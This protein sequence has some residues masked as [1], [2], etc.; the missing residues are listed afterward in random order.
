Q[1]DCALNNGGCSDGCIQGPF[2]AECTCQ[3]GYQLLNDSKTCDDIDECSIPGWCS[4]QCYNERGSFR[5]SCSD[6]YLLEPDNR[7]CKATDPTAAT[8][9][10]ASRSQIISSKVNLQ[11]P[12]IRPVVSGSDIVTVDFDRL[13]S[14]I[15]WADVSLKKIFTSF[16]NGTDRREVFSTGL[17]V[18]ES[19]AVDWVARNLYWTDSVMENIEVST[20]DGRFRKVLLTKNVTSPRGL[21]LD[22]RNH[23]NIM[24]WSD[25]GQNPRIEKAYMDGTGRQAI[26][27]TKLYW[28]NGLA[29]DYTTRRV[30]FADAYLKYIDYCDYNGNGRFQV[31]ASDM[32][33]QHPHGMTIFE[34]HIYWSERYTYQVLR[35]NKFHGGNTTTMIT[36][37]CLLSGFRPRYYTCHCQSG[38]NLNSDGRTCIKD[39]TPF[40]MVVRETVIFGIPVDPADPSN[41]AMVPVSG[42]TQGRDIDFDDQEQFV[43]W[44]QGSS[45]IYRVKTDGTNRTLFAPSAIIGSPSGLAFDWITRMMYYTNPTNKAIEVIRV[46]GVQLYR[47]TLITNT[48]KP[49]GAGEPIGIALDPARGKLFWTDRGIDSGVPPKVASADMDGGNLRNLYTINLGNIGF[50][51]A[52][53]AMSKLVTIVSQ[54]SHPWGL[55]VHQNYLYYTDLDYE[56]IERV[57]KGTGANMVVLRSG[58]TG[59]RALKVNARDNSAGTTNGCSTN[60]GACPHLCL[61]KPGGQKTCACT[62]GFVPSQDG[63]S[64]VQYDSYAV[65][66]TPRLIRG[67]HINSS[68]HSEAMVPVA[69]YSYSVMDKLDLHVASRYIYWIDNSTSSSYRGIFRAQT[70]GGSFTPVVNQGIGRG[71]IQG[72]AVDWIS[73]NLYFTNAVEA[74]TYLEVTRLET[75]YRTVLLK[76]IEDRPSDLAVSP[77]LR[78]LFW[79]DGGQN[80]KIERAQLDGANRTLLASE[81]LASPRGLTVDYTNDFLYW[82]DDVLDMISRM[83]PD[84]TQREIVRYGSR[85]PAPYGLSIFGNSMLWVDRKLGKL[86]QASKD[87]AN[88]TQP[89]VIRDGIDG[90]TD[91]VVFN[92]HV[93]PTAANL[94]GFNPCQEDNGRCQQLCFA[95]PEQEKPT[96]ACAHGSLLNNGVSCGYGLDEFLVFT[97][98]YTMNSLRLDPSDHTSPYPTINLGYNVVAL[99][100]DFADKRIFFTHYL[101]WTD[102]GIPAKIERATLGGNFRVPIINTSLSQPNG[103]SIDYEERMLYWAD[104]SLDKIERSTLTGESRQ[105]IMRGVQYPYAMTVFQQDIYWTDWT[106]RAVYRAGKDDGSGLTVLAQE[107]QYRPNDIHV[108]AGSKQEACS[109]PCQQYNGGC[110][111][112]CVPGPS[113]PECQCPA[114]GN[115][116]LAN[117]GMDCI[118]DNGNRCQPEQFTC[119]NGGCISVRSKCDGYSDCQDNSDE[120]ERVCAFHEC[121]AQDFTCDNGRCVPL[122]YVCD[123]TNDC[124]D[125]SDELG[126]PFPTCAPATEFTCANGRCISAAFVCDGYNDCRDNGTSDE[127]NCPPRTCPSGQ[128]KCDSTNICIY[129]SQLCDG[130]NNC[131]DNKDQI[132]TCHPDQF[133]C[134][135][136]NCIPMREDMRFSSVHL[137]PSMAPWS[138]ALYVC[139][140]EKDCADAAD[141]LQNCPNRTCHMNE[142]ACANGLCI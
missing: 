88:T 2:G 106:T 108:Y 46:D 91:V 20:L 115:W 14:R 69:G 47:K 139:D 13:T 11:P 43:Y 82:T 105:V 92:S 107:L 112:V 81:S 29:L 100:F 64:C 7:S 137:P 109:S 97:T 71:G 126:C 87:P 16:Q 37:L 89:E 34:D 104:A 127:I 53:I 74:Q 21:A 10:V 129:A 132:N 110:S 56:V 114:T 23:T 130:Y 124:G 90:L 134:T 118:H 72:M 54:L 61:P 12:L 102:W 45:S 42:I 103:L 19:I 44:V 1:E 75:P 49:E 83:A 22:P 62:T 121:S 119:L 122:S 73:G 111:H 18:P 52:D 80:P 79:A 123:Y 25:W 35:T 78:F 135:N 39:D 131:G 98:D 15:Y 113:G 94:V 58:M 136:G 65:V 142:F 5:C 141:E 3:P 86:F 48:G 120:L 133:T 50:I 24:F 138:P 101:Y 140:G 38:W 76:S 28:P 57:D 96:C 63:T 17:M 85:Y 116:Y 99:D 6:G 68:D 66:S 36:N 125:N 9:L 26:V 77:K 55:T 40:L 27:T 117:N 95:L 41:N 59:V 31:M 8:L 32:V 70:D 33:L 67:F 60:N 51:T 128:T 93:Q 84:G 30:Y 4:Q